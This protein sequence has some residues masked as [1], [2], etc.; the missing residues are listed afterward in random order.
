MQN[1][2][3]PAFS[4]QA[5]KGSGG[6][7]HIRGGGT[8]WPWGKCGGTDTTQPYKPQLMLLSVPAPSG[9]EQWEAKDG[10]AMRGMPEPFSAPIPTNLFWSTCGLR[11][12]PLPPAQPAQQRAPA[13][14]VLLSRD[15]DRGRLHLAMPPYWCRGWCWW[16]D[17]GQIG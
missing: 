7:R 14:G 8:A 12:L 15:A 1:S 6:Q 17:D 16:Q 10:L 5:S 3:V 4:H 2:P 11:A 13:L 9:K